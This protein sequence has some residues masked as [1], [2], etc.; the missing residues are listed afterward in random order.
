[1]KLYEIAEA[2][3]AFMDAVEAGEIPAE[4][5]PDT[6]AGIDGEF[7]DKAENIAKII[8]SNKS[9]IAGYEFEIDRLS[10][11]RDAVKNQN[12]RLNAYLFDQMKAIGKT[13]IKTPLFGFSICKNG[14]LQPMEITGDVPAQYTKS[15]PDNEKIRKALTDGEALSFASFKERGEHLR[16]R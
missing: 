16:I 2:F 6:L 4:A 5:I 13:K 7:E 15:E 12:T 11:L 10:K 3:R 9:D 8:S 1:M 14:G